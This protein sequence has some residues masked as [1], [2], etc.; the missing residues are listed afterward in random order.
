MLLL[1]WEQMHVKRNL[2]GNI[3]KRKS[4]GVLF[5]NI[6]DMVMCFTHFTRMNTF[7]QE[8]LGS[9]VLKFK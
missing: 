9:S 4:I 6:S 5:V 3:L 1:I 8:Y 2:K 7:L